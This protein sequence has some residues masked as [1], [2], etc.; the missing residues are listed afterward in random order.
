[1]IALEAC[2]I[3]ETITAIP[4]SG[5]HSC[6]A[7]DSAQQL[8]ARR[9][10][11]TAAATAR[12]RS[13]GEAWRNTVEVPPPTPPPPRQSPFFHAYKL[14]YCTNKLLYTVYNLGLWNWVNFC[15]FVY[16][17]L[18]WQ[19]SFLNFGRLRTFIVLIGYKDKLMLNQ[20]A[21]VFKAVF[22]AYIC[23]KSIILKMN[24]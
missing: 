18:T 5:A 22:L 16:G 9:A 20:Q 23:G 4:L 1:M 12:R 13:W 10:R 6:L 11:R 2:L 17:G 3:L 19:W 15:L 14:D 21:Y 8:R 24:P 7:Q